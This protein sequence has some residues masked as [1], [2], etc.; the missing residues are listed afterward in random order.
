MNS[1]DESTRK[2]E[3]RELPRLHVQTDIVPEGVAVFHYENGNPTPLVEV[4]HASIEQDGSDTDRV[5][6]RPE[7]TPNPELPRNAES[8]RTPPRAA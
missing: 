6:E 2:S 5:G 3:E 8:L 7:R 1:E 4:Q